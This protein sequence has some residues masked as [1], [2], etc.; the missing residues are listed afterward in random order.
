MDVGTIIANIESVFLV[1]IWFLGFFT[2]NGPSWTVSTLFFFYVIFPISLVMA[3]VWSLAKST[4]FFYERLGNDTLC[5]P[6]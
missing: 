5:W 4:Q 6:K 3:Q 1:N 2:A